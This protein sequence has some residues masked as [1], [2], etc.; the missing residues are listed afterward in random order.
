V[1]DSSSSGHTPSPD[2]FD[3]W[4]RRNGDTVSAARWEL[5]GCGLSAEEAARV[6]DYWRRVHPHRAIDVRPHLSGGPGSA[7]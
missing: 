2:L 7:R 5:R 6:A 4:Q 1:I 3:I